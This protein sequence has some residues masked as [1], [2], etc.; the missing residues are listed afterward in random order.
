MD[1]V[2]QVRAEGRALGRRRACQGR[3]NELSRIDAPVPVA[4][5]SVQ[6]RGGRL[7]PDQE[8]RDHMAPQGPW[9]RDTHNPVAVEP[10]LRAALLPLHPDHDHLVTSLHERRGLPSHPRVVADRIRDEHADLHGVRLN[11]RFNNCLI[12]TACRISLEFRSLC[13]WASPDC[14]L[15][16]SCLSNSNS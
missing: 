4:Q 9:Q 1:E 12:H 11:T 6:A 14:F 15:R 7:E 2:Q 3:R 5:D 10:F 13:A 16:S 8:V